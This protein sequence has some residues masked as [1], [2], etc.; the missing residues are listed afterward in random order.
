MGIYGAMNTSVAGMAVQADRI[1]AVADNIANAS[2]TGYKRSEVE[3]ETLM[4]SGLSNTGQYTSGSVQSHTTRAVSDPGTMAYTG[5]STNLAI[6]GNGFF[7]VQTPAGQ[8]ALTRAGAFAPDAEGNLVNTAGMKL[9]GVDITNGDPGITSNSAAGLVPIR[10]GDLSMRPVP[11][12]AGELAVNLPPDATIIAGANLPAANAASAQYT[13]KTSL[14]GYD[15]LGASVMLDVFYAKTGANTWQVSVFDRDLAPTTG[16]FPY[17]GPALTSATLDF[18]PTT[19]MLTSSS[20]SSL[21][22]PVP[23]GGSLALDLGS[24]SQV[25][26]DFAVKAAFVNGSAPVDVEQIEISDKGI[27]SAIYKDGSRTECFRIP[28]AT[29]PSPDRLAAISGNAFLPSD[30]SG[31]LLITVAGS[32]GTGLLVAGAL[33]GANVDLADELTQMIQAQ[34]SYTANSKVFQAGAEMMDVLV[35]LRT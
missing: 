22:I 13:A 6:S 18:D 10:P 19:G 11:S 35:N 29:V 23:N 30:D 8:A 27:V 4:V 33:E 24:T 26:A 7:V 16:Q 1:G 12:S 31:D 32:G 34:R 28:L 2:T 5:V 3:F 21:T 14:V 9:L 20:A 17:L 15:N 25:A